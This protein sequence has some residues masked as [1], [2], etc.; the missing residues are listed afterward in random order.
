MGN[1][2]RGDASFEGRFRGAYY[3]FVLFLNK[4]FFGNGFDAVNM[5]YI[6]M[7]HNNVA[8]VA[9]DFGVFA[10]LIEEFFIIFPLFK[11]IKFQPNKQGLF[12]PFLPLAFSALFFMLFFQLFLVSF[13]S[14]IE[15]IMIPMSFSLLG[16]KDL[17][18]D[19]IKICISGEKYDYYRIDI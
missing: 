11:I 19:K 6:I 13:N 1:G 5:N 4:P 15:S 10:L 2:S 8:E 9:A 7:A 17:K 18:V 16:L 3:G 14:K 12:S